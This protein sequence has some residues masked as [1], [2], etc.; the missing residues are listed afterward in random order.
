MRALLALVGGTPR[1]KPEPAPPAVGGV[2]GLLVRLGRGV[3][4][5]GHELY[6]TFIFYGRLL[7]A[8]AQARGRPASVP[9]GSL[10]C[11]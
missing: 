8:L 10:P 9:P 4:H 5:L 6:H 1:A 3:A 2:Y 7:S 11:R